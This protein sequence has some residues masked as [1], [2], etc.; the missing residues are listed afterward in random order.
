[1]ALSARIY[2]VLV[3]VGMEHDIFRAWLAEVDDLT[4]AQRMEL[5]AV[6]A[7]QPPRGAVTAL[8]EASPGNERTCPHCGHEISVRCGKANDLQRYRCKRC[9]KSFNALTATPLARL[10]KKERWLDFAQSL[11]EGDTVVT[12]AERCG[13]AVSTAFRW[14][15]RFLTAEAPS[16]TLGGIVEADEAFVRLSF[17]GS[18]MW[19]QAEKGMPV[20]GLPDRKARKRGGKAAKRGLS[21]EQVPVLVASDRTGTF[22]SAVL[23]ADNGDAIQ[24]VLGPILSKDALLVT[25]GGK[26][27]A[28]CATQM[29]VTHEALNLSAGER[30]RGE[31]HIQTVNS[32][33]SRLKD[34]LRLRRGVATKY[35]D[36]YL[37]WFQRIG[38]G[39]G[40]SPRAC[41]NS[42]IGSQ[43]RIG[44]PS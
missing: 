40:L 23:S 27:L 14:R 6:L 41:L 5:E 31:L 33:H 11:G 39:K 9:G 12:S 7:G 13:V 21:H 37:R 38:T 16:P 29:K 18:R 4:V 36:A 35:L 43:L 1:M 30:V 32:L 15:H 28:R 20:T 8:I 44:V 34:F 19:E 25:D 42:A 17:K 3:E 2:R 22:V 26:A 10:R 24:A